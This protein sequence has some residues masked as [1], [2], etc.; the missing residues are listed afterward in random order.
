M[1]RRSLLGEKF[2]KNYS[3][4]ELYE[5][6]EKLE[7]LESAIYSSNEVNYEQIRAQ[8]AIAILQGKMCDLNAMRKL[9]ILSNED[10]HS[11]HK[12]L[13]KNSVALADVLVN[14]LIETSNNK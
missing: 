13:A 6:Y 12:H 5:I 10:T 9:W 1:M 7:Q 14:E 2:T 11:F 4:M 3:D 8:A